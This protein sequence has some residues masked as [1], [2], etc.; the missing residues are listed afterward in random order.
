MTY[1]S[2]KHLDGKHTVFG[3]IVGGLDSLSAIEK[4]ETDNKDKPIEDIII[5]RANVFVDPFADVDQ[6]LGMF[7]HK[8]SLRT[9]F[10]HKH[11]IKNFIKKFD[12]LHEK[13]FNDICILVHIW[14]QISNFEAYIISKM[15][16]KF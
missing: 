12:N 6:E 4:I 13:N 8:M 10:G 16:D 7:S 9:I 14:N 2:C 3:K 15:I 11:N 5:Q 1:R